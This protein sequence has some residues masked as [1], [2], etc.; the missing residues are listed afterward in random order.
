MDPIR[1]SL[2][3][4]SNSVSLP[5]LISDFLAQLLFLIPAAAAAAAGMMCSQWIIVWRS[6]IPSRRP[7]TRHQNSIWSDCTRWNASKMF[8]IK[9]SSSKNWKRGNNWTRIWCRG[10]LQFCNLSCKLHACKGL[11][12]CCGNGRRTRDFC[13]KVCISTMICAQSLF[14][15]GIVGISAFFLIFCGVCFTK[16]RDELSHFSS[17]L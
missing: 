10:P 8:C 7:P 4:N 16:K 3:K 9:S 2:G 1:S 5:N 14:C 12:K 11:T 6:A 13:L 17:F 15:I